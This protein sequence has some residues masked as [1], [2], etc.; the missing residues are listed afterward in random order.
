MQF[1]TN[2]A[3]EPERQVTG[4]EI[5]FI[6][7][8]ILQIICSIFDV[9]FVVVSI[10]VSNTNGNWCQF[11]VPQK[12]S[13]FIAYLHEGVP[14]SFPIQPPRQICLPN[15]KSIRQ[16]TRWKMHYLLHCHGIPVVRVDV[17]TCN[18]WDRLRHNN[19][20]V[21]I[22]DHKGNLKEK[23]IYGKKCAVNGKR[24]VFVFSCKL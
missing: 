20:S 19:Q 23:T 2:R 5:L 15:T 8:N 11:S 10:C 3:R 4:N 1:W 18:R 16:H 13:I 6:N 9:S 12:N 24:N 21:T 22:Y 7:T 14:V 17:S